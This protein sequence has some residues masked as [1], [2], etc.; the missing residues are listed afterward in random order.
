MKK[1]LLFSLL[2]LCIGGANAQDPVF[3][4]FHS[5]SLW[6][7]PALTGNADAMRLSNNVRFQ[8][9]GISGY[10][11]TQAL[12]F[13]MPV[14][15]D[16]LG[17]GFLFLHDNAAGV[18]HTYRFEVP[19]AVRLPMARGRYVQIGV[20]PG[21]LYQHLN[22]EKLLFGDMIDPRRGLIYPVGPLVI[23]PD[24][25][26]FDLSAGVSFAFD[27]LLGG[28]SASHLA[29]PRSGY[30]GDSRQPVHY[31]LHAAAIL[32]K[33]PDEFPNSLT[34][35]P[36]VQYHAEDN[37]RMLH[38]GIT[39]MFNHFSLGLSYR[40]SDAAIGTVGYRAKRF[41]VGYSYDYTI[42]KLTNVTGGAHELAVQYVFRKK[43]TVPGEPAFLDGF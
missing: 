29:R 15:R 33:I 41:R 17:A 13:D 5:S 9:P 7:N 39:F 40:E 3:T 31:A 4:Q 19:V 38:G 37:F 10:Y 11:N 8:W 18:I 23:N 21:L 14:L 30:F 24:R 12:S 36:A 34:V 35:V 25:Y 16:R 2:S 27:R 1:T 26:S 32:G 43:E 22:M 28:F 42:S 6:L 20:S